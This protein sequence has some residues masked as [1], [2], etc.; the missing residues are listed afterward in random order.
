MRLALF[1]IAAVII[2][3]AGSP[4]CADDG[5]LGALEGR[6]AL[7]RDAPD[8]FDPVMK[9]LEVPWLLRR[10]AGVGSIEFGLEVIPVEACADCPLR[11]RMSEAT[12]VRAT[13]YEVTT[14]GVFRDGTDPAGNETRDAWTSPSEGRL[15]LERTR[16]LP[17]GKK[18]RITDTRSIGTTPNEMISILTVNI[19]REPAPESRRVFVRL[20]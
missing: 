5:G 14:D 15:R 4:G 2:A 9:A 8:S 1:A 3:L 19:D 12:P 6:W 17:S 13:E 18:T 16:T 10:L 11:I 20:P 7:D